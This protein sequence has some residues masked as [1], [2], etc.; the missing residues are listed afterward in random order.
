MELSRILSE[1]PMGLLTAQKY[2][3][4][5]N[6]GL[7]PFSQQVTT[8][9]DQYEYRLGT[10]LSKLRSGID[11]HR[12]WAA[13]DISQGPREAGEI[14]GE[15]KIFV[16]TCQRWRLKLKDQVILLGYQSADSIGMQILNGRVRAHSR[17]IK[18]RSGYVIAISIGLGILYGESIDAENQW[19]RNPRQILDGKSPLDYMLGG[20]MID[21]IT[22]NRMVERERGL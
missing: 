2:Q 6:R 14:R 20:Q 19:L 4:A 11:I 22:I 9:S 16:E 12:S 1:A 10:S 17:D 7:H 15:L 21:L 13:S 5:V 18:D 8:Y 3:Q